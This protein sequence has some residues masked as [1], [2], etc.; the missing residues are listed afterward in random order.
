MGI[1]T[2]NFPQI[3]EKFLT[4]PIFSATTHLEY[5]LITKQYAQS[6]LC[7]GAKSTSLF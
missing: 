2:P 5:W 7:L 6:A 3:P 1:F 4:Y